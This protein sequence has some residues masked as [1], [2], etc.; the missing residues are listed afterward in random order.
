MTDSFTPGPW[1]HRPARIKSDGGV[2]HCISAVVEG[3]SR[4]IA[5]AF[6]VIAVNV[7][8][9]AAANARLIAAAPDILSALQLAA[10]E[11]NAI[12]AR[13]GAPQHIDWYKCRPLQTSSCTD[14]WW[15]ELTEMCFAAIKK[16][17]V[18]LEND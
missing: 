16:A 10:R 6:N 13:D 2:D 12:R 17:G 15:N 9:N 5:E 3:K 1:A 18:A 7:E 4:C 14:E 11:L 8:V